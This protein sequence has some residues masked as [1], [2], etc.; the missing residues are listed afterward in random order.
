MESIKM[1]MTDEQKI[2]IINKIVVIIII[3]FLTKIITFLIKEDSPLFKKAN[4]NIKDAVINTFIYKVIRIVIWTISVFIIIK[5]LGYDLTGI[6]TG[7]GLGSVVIALAAQD[8]VKSL[9]SGITILID[10]PFVVG[11]NIEVGK[12]QGTVIEITY[13]STRIKTAN[14]SMIT[15]PNSIITSEYVVNWNKMTRRKF[16]CT[17]NLNLETSSEKVKKLIQQ[18]QLVFKEN[19]KVIKDTIQ[20]NLN[21][22]SDNGIEINILLFVW[23]TNYK[24]YLKIKE[25]LL[26]VLLTLI[27]KENIDLAYPKQKIYLTDNEERIEE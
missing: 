9:L 25:E 15:I 17:L 3:I 18:I 14:Q 10:K 1:L 20:I 11:D 22:V 23:E 12:Y 4:K 21:S 8:V 24:K 26:Y 16:E 6:I 2:Y 19:P 13:R 27:E 5:E 7:F